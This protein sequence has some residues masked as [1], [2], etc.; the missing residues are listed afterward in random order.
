MSLADK[1]LINPLLHRLFLD[2]D[3]NSI[4]KIQEKIK[5]SFKYFGK[6]SICSIRANA[7]FSIVFS[8]LNVLHD[9]SKAS[10]GVVME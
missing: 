8:N 2:H 7:P 10:K 6:W 3:I 4:E 5:L 9:I 1:E